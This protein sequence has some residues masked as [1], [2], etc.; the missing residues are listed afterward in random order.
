MKN[1][2]NILVAT[3]LLLVVLA[4]CHDDGD[5][6]VKTVSEIEVFDMDGFIV[7]D[8][9]EQYFDGKKVRDVYGRA[10]LTNA[11]EIA[12][13]NDDVVMEFRAHRTG[14]TVYTQTFNIGDSTH[15]VPKFYFDGKT[16]YD[17]Y[18]RP[19]PAEGEYLVNFYFDFPERE[20]PVDVVAQMLEYYFNWDLPD[21]MVIVDTIPVILFNNIQPGKWSEYMPLNPLPAM[22]P[23]RPDSEFWPA[24]CL[25]KAGQTVGYYMSGGI[26]ANSMSLE[27]REPWMTQGKVQSI[28]IGLTPVGPDK[29]VL[30]PQYNLVDMFP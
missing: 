21:P 3:S 1:I 29:M 12:F 2:V 10:K 7:G 8:T 13:E 11:Q 23:S 19:T 28:Y 24:I 26:T 17:T 18:P 25:R 5:R 16:L 15:V 30:Y 14:E 4:A 20:G 27:L 6:I 9:L 22:V